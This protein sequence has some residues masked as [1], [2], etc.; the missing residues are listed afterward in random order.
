MDVRLF[1]I[2]AVSRRM[3]EI[4]LLEHPERVSDMPGVFRLSFRAAAFSWTASAFVLGRDE[5]VWL[6]HPHMS[7]TIQEVL[8]HE[9]LHIVLN[10]IG[11]HDASMRLDRTFAR[12][13]LRVRYFVGETTEQEVTNHY[14]NRATQT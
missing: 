4:Y 9:A 7:H 3:R 10:R 5:T 14:A 11:E 6:C 12:K 1:D 8:A 13:R 2:A